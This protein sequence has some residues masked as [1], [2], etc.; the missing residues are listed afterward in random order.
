MQPEDLAGPL[1]EVLNSRPGEQ[2]HLRNYL[3][4]L[5]SN[6]APLSK[7]PN[8]REREVSIAITEAWGWLV[9]EGLLAVAHTASQYGWYV[10]SRRGRTLKG[11]ADFATYRSASRL[12][13]DLLHP[14]LQEDP[15]LNFIRGKFDTAVFEAFREVEVVVREAGG[16]GPSDIGADLMRKAFDP[17]KGPLTRQSDE[18]GE[19]EGL[20]HL[21]AG[22]ISSYKNPRSHRKPGLDDALDAIEMLVLASHLLRIVDARGPS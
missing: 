8:A 18:R 19:R 5:F 6:H 9:H 22:A 4:E 13:R 17:A 15:W 12:P 2:V 7:Y 10:V 1:L 14:K 20:S 11:K 3:G 21:F 16:F